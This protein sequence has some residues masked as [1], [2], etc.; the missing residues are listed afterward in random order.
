MNSDGLGRT[1]D[2]SLLLLLAE[3]FGFLDGEEQLLFQLL[4]ALIGRQVQ[5]VEAERQKSR[6]RKGQ[7]GSDNWFYTPVQRRRKLLGLCGSCG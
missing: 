5:T 7:S 4:V 3:S 6:I 1:L 2:D